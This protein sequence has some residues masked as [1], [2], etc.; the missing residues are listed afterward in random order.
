MPSSLATA[1]DL[2]LANRTI[3]DLRATYHLFTEKQGVVYLFSRS[4]STAGVFEADEG[5]AA[6][7]DVPFG[8]DVHDFAELGED[9]QQSGL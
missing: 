9:N 2:S 5:L 4:P 8:A 1:S 6:H 3:C 7:P